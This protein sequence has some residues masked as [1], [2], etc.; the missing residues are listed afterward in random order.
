VEEGVQR[1]L[2]SLKVPRR[3]ELQE[4]EARLNRLAARIDALGQRK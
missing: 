3:D 2:V 4:F 1:T